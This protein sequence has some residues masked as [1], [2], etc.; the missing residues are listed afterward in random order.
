V[1]DDNFRA[2]TGTLHRI[3][4]V[5]NSVGRPAPV[6]TRPPEDAVVAAGEGVTF[7]VRA[8]GHSPLRYEWQRDGK[9]IAG[10]DKPD[11]E[12]PAASAG[13]DGA[14]FQCVVSNGFG[15][16]KSRPATLRDAAPRAGRDWCD[17]AGGDGRV[18]RGRVEAAPGVRRHACRADG[19]R[20]DD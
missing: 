18:L 17:G 11:Y 10:G 1:K 7:H 12:L 5:A 4:H 20:S 3:F 13:D 9:T 8:V 16:S 14:A 19:S 2:N 6:V 15:A